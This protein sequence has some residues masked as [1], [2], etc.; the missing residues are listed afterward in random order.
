MPYIP[1]FYLFGHDLDMILMYVLIY[2]SFQSLSR[3]WI[4]V[5]II[6]FHHVTVSQPWP[7]PF[8]NQSMGPTM[9]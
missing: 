5:C 8:T 9:P 1:I 7:K 3:F 6:I 2:V 4:T